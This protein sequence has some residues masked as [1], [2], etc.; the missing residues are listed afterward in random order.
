MSKVIGGKPTVTKCL[1]SWHW[2]L[3]RS[4]CVLALA[5][6]IGTVGH[7]TIAQATCRFVN[8]YPTGCYPIH[9]R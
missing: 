1:G 5:G 7:P 8:V 4:T 9:N 3:P 2:W 6:V